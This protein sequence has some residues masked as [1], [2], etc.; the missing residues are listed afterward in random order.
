M[1]D[2]NNIDHLFDNQ[3]Q[4][5]FEEPNQGHEK[6]FVAK[7]R[8]QQ[9]TPIKRKTIWI[10][11]SIAAS[12]LLGF[13]IF[14]FN[15]TNS[16]TEKIAFSPQV[17]ETHDYFSSVINTELA[18]LKKNETPQS[19]ALIRD[20]MNE[21]ETLEK[22]YDKLKEEISKNGE[23]KQIVF[24]MITNMQTR[25]SFIKTVLEQVESINNLKTEKD[26]NHI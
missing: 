17:Q 7:L 25:I 2:K 13:G 11:L 5:D 18:S 15:S 16:A 3:N 10:P 4:W 9:I 21:M 1:N 23:N 20:A 6:R 19:K 26:E 24:A 12:L 22:D 8:K 14:Y